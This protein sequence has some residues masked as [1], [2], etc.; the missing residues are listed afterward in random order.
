MAVKKKDYSF[1]DIK[2]KYSTTT[3][4]KADKF[5]NC[6]EAFL[7]TAGIPGPAVGHINML[8]GHSDTGK[9]TAMIKSAISAQQQ[10][11]IPVFIITEKKWDFSHAFLM[12]LECEFNN[13]TGEW[14]GDFLYRDDFFYIEQITDYINMLLDEQIKGSIP[15]DL[16]FFW[17]S[18]GSVP[19]RMTYEG[20]GG[21][22]HTA[23]VLAEKIGMGLNQRIN[24]TRKEDSKYTNTM[25]VVN[26]P[27]VELPDNPFGQPRIKAKGGD[28][29][30]LNS[31]LVFLFGNQKNAGTSK[32][33]ATKNGRKVVF[34]TRT[35][36]TVM[37][38]HVNGLGYADGRIIATP[39]G[40][41]LDNK[42]SIDAYKKEHAS[43]WV[44]M[45]GTNDFE[46]IEEQGKTFTSNAK[47]QE[48]ND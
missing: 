10:G 19:C 35:K 32:I 9:T 22:Q 47:P 7:E 33:D 14:D 27:W 11:M 15:H 3:K 26:Q 4:Y 48:E 16:C 41:V 39:H 28:A 43:Y 31:T 23:G 13:E 20:K 36:V 1:K 42:E 25:V 24:S 6:G 18:V 21:K 40:F 34:A 29:F 37:K 30:W 2:N 17:D 38:N 46:L 12:G 45:L 44:E 8:L 5:L